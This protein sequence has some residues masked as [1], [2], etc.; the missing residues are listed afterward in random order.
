[1]RVKFLLLLLVVCGVTKAQEIPPL[2]HSWTPVSPAIQAPAL[3]LPNLDDEI[4]DLARL[5]DSVVLIN[6]WATWCPPC[7]REMPSLDRLANALKGHS[8]K[9]LTINIGED[10]ETIFG[11][12]GSLNID[13]EFEFLLD[14]EAET[15]QPWGVKGL[16]TSYVVDSNGQV[17]MRAVGGR[18]FDH[19]EMVRSLIDLSAE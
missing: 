11:F 3:V 14:L 7:R 8:V 15:L 12:M 17:V 13:P 9:I 1:M 2:S 10:F 18:E 16:P 6:F 19:P 5:E 4:I